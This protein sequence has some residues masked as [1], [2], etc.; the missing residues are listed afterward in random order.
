MQLFDRVPLRTIPPNLITASGM[1]VGIVSMFCASTGD[2]ETAGWLIALAA[3]IDKLDGSVARGLRGSSAFGV[4][5]D[6][7][8]DFVTFGFAPAALCF[9][10]AP[11][12]APAHWGPSAAPFLGLVS[13]AAALATI[14]VLYILCAAVRLAKF[15][16]I[17]A[18]S[19]GWFQGLPSTLSGSLIALIFVAPVE[20]G[21]HGALVP[22]ILPVLLL[23]NS[24]LMVC[25]LP[26]PK[27]RLW[28]H[29]VLRVIQIANG[30]AV[31]VMV[32]LRFAFWYPLLILVT[33]VL[34][35][36]IYGVRTR[37]GQ[38]TAEPAVAPG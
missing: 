35:G 32:P 36:F 15:N 10:A 8:S 5:F 16:I 33:Y 6:S 30:V 34:V 21:Y 20:L 7:F 24:G 26:L 4:Q 25:N 22:S 23:L 2:Y 9:F 19:P 13:P 14:C 38:S 11:D 37:G 31:Y 29:P 1:A 18:E 27:L 12:L 17:T 28:R 3:L